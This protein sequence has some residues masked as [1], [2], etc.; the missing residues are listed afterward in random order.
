VVVTDNRVLGVDA[1]KTGWVGIVLD[2]DAQPLGLWAARIDE[3]IAKAPDVAVVVIDIPIG[4]PDIGTR[5]ADREARVFVGPRRSSVFMTPTRATLETD[6]YQEANRLARETSGP[7]ISRQ[8]HALRTKILEVD[9]WI[10]TTSLD[11]REGHP[12]VSFRVLAGEPLN[13][14]RC[15]A[16]SNA[17]RELLERE[18]VAL[19]DSLG[20]AGIKAAVDDVLDAAV[21]AW[22]ARRI[23]GGAARA[24]PATPPRDQ[25]GRAVAIWV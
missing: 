3:L 1:C 2:G 8:A 25:A 9:A 24:L 23:A 12:E 20:D 15:W 6:D 5:A 11:V 14:K 16:G 13:S 19:D 4:L 7:G 10:G 18:G 21:M 17:R 22:T